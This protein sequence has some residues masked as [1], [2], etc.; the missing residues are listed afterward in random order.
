M[1]TDYLE[2]NKDALPDVVLYNCV[3]VVCL[4]HADKKDTVTALKTADAIISELWRLSE[5]IPDLRPTMRMYDGVIYKYVELKIPVRAH[6]LL[7]ELLLTQHPV[8]GDP[9]NYLCLV[10]INAWEASKNLWKQSFMNQIW[11]ASV[12]GTEGFW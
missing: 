1:S 9:S 8:V 5:L 7:M 10:V 12:S 6:T 2:G 4:A 11:D 3:V